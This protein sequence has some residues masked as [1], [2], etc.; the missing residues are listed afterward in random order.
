M[1][2]PAELISAYSQDEVHNFSL[3]QTHMVMRYEGNDFVCMEITPKILITHTDLL[4]IILIE[5]PCL[6]KT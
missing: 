1:K 3:L 4:L 2:F 5:T 6:L